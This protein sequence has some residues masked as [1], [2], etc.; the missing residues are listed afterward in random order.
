MDHPNGV[1]A[2]GRVLEWN[3]PQTYAYEWNLA[4]GPS[5]PQGETTI[6]RWELTPTE[7]GTLLV[8]THRK[9]SRS[10][11]EVFVRGLPVLLDRLSAQLDGTP[12][13]DPP[14]GTQATHPR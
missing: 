3:P 14:W 4:A 10:T 8:L 2:T 1:H 7:G 9:L 5:H 11:A 12:L 6:V 13:P